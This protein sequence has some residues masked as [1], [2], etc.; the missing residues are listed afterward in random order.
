MLPN[1]TSSTKCESELT[2]CDEVALGRLSC[3][4]CVVVVA[5]AR[6]VTGGATGRSGAWP[7]SLREKRDDFPDKA[8]IGRFELMEK[9]RGREPASS[10]ALFNAAE[11]IERRDF[12][13]HLGARGGAILGAG[14]GAF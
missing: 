13:P 8:E 1:K 3:G 9:G 5:G 7:R 12:F 6:S 2:G 10:R 11:I 14:N 4:G